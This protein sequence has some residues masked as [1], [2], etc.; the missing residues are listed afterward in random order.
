M[1]QVTA[2]SPIETVR[3][4]GTQRKHRCWRG[5]AALCCAC[6]A[7]AWPGVPTAARG[8][9]DA[10]TRRLRAARW[11]SATPSKRSTTPRENPEI[12]VVAAATRTHPFSLTPRA[13]TSR[14]RS[15]QST[16]RTTTSASGGRRSASATLFCGASASRAFSTRSLRTSRFVCCTACCRTNARI[17][18]RRTWEHT[19]TTRTICRSSLSSS[20]LT[21]SSRAAH[22]PHRSAWTCRADAQSERTQSTCR[23]STRRAA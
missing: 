19:C 15:T 11:P 16:R 18:F 4:G 20:R 22:P 14:S 5:C 9:T 3:V 23:V 10:G 1:A 2:G 6:R 8:S 12:K 13:E 17:F 7:A 21:F